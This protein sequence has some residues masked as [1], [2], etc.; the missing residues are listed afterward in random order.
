MQRCGELLHEIV[1][2]PGYKVP[3]GHADRLKELEGRT[4][5]LPGLFLIGNGY[6]GVGLPDCVK[7][8]KD[9]AFGIAG[10]PATKPAYAA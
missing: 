10:V 8:G 7:M 2:V 1:A 3:V 9:A 4:A 5:Q 6:R